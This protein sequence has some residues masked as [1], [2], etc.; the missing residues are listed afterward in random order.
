[1]KSEEFQKLGILKCPHHKFKKQINIL[2]FL[3]L[4]SLFERERKKAQVRGGAEG[5]DQQADS[6]LSEE[7]NT[8]I[9][10]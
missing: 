4:K 5:G 7:P 3:F 10:S 9:I 8:K 6:L 2:Y 1:M